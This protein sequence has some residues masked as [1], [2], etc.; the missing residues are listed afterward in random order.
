MCR[1]H[2]IKEKQQA[3]EDDQTD[4]RYADQLPSIVSILLLIE[5]ETM[6]SGVSER[7]QI[8]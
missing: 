7:V 5:H 1:S 3:G 6:I 2:V 8:H 4:D